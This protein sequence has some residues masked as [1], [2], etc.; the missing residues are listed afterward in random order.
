[1]A[2]QESEE[3][4]RKFGSTNDAWQQVHVQVCN[5][6]SG[7]VGLQMHCQM[8]KEVTGCSWQSLYLQKAALGYSGSGA[9]V[10]T[11]IHQILDVVA[12]RNDV[13][14]GPRC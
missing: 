1:V 8:W 4:R 9:T 11:N 14:R 6:L 12:S 7:G 2:G 3:S 10:N 5:S 13:L